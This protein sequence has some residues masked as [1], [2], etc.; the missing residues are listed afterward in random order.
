MVEVD[1]R[2]HVT[3]IAVRRLRLHRPDCSERTLRYPDKVPNRKL[4]GVDVGRVCAA[5][6]PVTAHTPSLSGQRRAACP[7]TSAASATAAAAALAASSARRPASS[8]GATVSR[9]DAD[10]GSASENARE[11]P[12]RAEVTSLGM[13][14]TEL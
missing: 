13:T 6:P 3:G 5:H 2:G 7:S 8:S 12:C 10:L 11:I 9:V 14:N 4:S 1:A